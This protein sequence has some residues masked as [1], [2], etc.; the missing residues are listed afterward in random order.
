LVKVYMHITYD[1]YHIIC[2]YTEEELVKVCLCVCVCVSKEEEL[3]KV[4]GGLCLWHAKCATYM[5]SSEVL[6]VQQIVPS[7]CLC[8][9]VSV[10]LCVCLYMWSSKALR[11]QQLVNHYITTN[12]AVC[13][14]VSVCLSVHVVKQGT[15]SRTTSQLLVRL[16]PWSP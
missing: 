14:S 9:C 15:Q 1:I 5:R 13:V 16:V 7:V 12:S 4:T 10:C 11:V 6:S 8:V 3:V 2:M